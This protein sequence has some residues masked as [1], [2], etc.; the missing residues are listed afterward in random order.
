MKR[1]QILPFICNADFPEKQRYLNEMEIQ[2]IWRR[3]SYLV[4]LGTIVF[5]IIIGT[6]GL[7]FLFVYKNNFKNATSLNFKKWIVVFLSLFWL[8][9]AVDL[10]ATM[11][12]SVFPSFKYYSIDSRISYFMNMDKEGFPILECIMGT[13]VLFIVIF[14]F[15]PKQERFT[16]LLSG[17][18]GGITGVYLWF[19]LI[20]KYL[21]P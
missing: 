9:A 15:I 16:F 1:N 18:F 20:G 7:I 14:Q 2:K 8:R 12:S 4:A 5:P 11:V 13:T 21:L 3:H 19:Y 10:W 6:L 17:L